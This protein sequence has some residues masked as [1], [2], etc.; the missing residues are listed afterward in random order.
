MGTQSVTCPKEAGETRGLQNLQLQACPAFKVAILLS[1]ADAC[2]QRSKCHPAQ[3]GLLLVMLTTQSVSC[4]APGSEAAPLGGPAVSSE[5]QSAA[6]IQE[7]HH[8]HPQD[9][10]ATSPV[11]Q[12]SFAC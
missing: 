9:Q 11:V 12:F 3:S 2:V 4:F 6:R 1:Q 8:L 10:E 7:Q 5:S